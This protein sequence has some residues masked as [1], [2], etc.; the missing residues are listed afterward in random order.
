MS[1]FLP[2]RS[3]RQ[4]G[5]LHRLPP[6]AWMWRPADHRAIAPQINRSHHLLTQTQI[7][8]ELSED[9][10]P[11]ASPRHRT[12]KVSFSIP[13]SPSKNSSAGKT[14]R[15]RAI[16]SMNCSPRS[17]ASQ[18]T[19]RR[20]MTLRLSTLSGAKPP[21]LPASGSDWP[22]STFPFQRKTPMKIV[23]WHLDLKM[24]YA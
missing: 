24:A 5:A 18:E 14:A 13:T 15:P 22:R 4:P 11:T 2:W 7:C 12:S 1:G 16:S 19:L 21:P 6:L 8:P 10:K 17:N 9:V 3:Q 23:R 20:A